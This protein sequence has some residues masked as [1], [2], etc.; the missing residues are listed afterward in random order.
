[1]ATD[2]LI[3]RSTTTGAVP[4][5]SDLST[6]E[7]AINT[8]DKRLFTNN[9]GTIVEIGTAPTSLA[10]TNNATVGGTLGVT[11]NTTVAT[12][13]A[14]NWTVTG[15]LTVATPSASTD[16][17]SKGYVDTADA[18]KVDKAGDTMSG[19]LAMGTN[20]ITGLGTPT[21]STD[22]ATKGYVDAQVTAVIDSAPG[23][24]DT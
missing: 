15:T 21:L 13:T 2:I 1:M 8:V 11:G 3:K 20:K 5:T 7:L 23:A 22:A 9:S 6:G 4:T 24:L 17:A 18:L 19:D 12:G 16:A 14:T 10:V